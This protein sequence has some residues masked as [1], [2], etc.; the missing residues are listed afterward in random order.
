[1]KVRRKLVAAAVGFVTFVF[2]PLGRPKPVFE[3]GHA[4]IRILSVTKDG[5][6]IAESMVT[7]ELEFRIEQGQVD[8]HTVLE[9]EQDREMRRAGDMRYPVIVLKHGDVKLALLGVD[10]TV[11]K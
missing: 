10:L 3:S 5:T 8:A 2:P 1:M 4:M 7:P 6:A 9:L 11:K